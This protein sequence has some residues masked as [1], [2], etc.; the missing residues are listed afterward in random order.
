MPEV[1]IQMPGSLC[2]T[3][4]GEVCNGSCITTD[5]RQSKCRLCRR[6][7]YRFSKSS[8]QSIE[9]IEAVDWDEQPLGK[10]SDGALARMFDCDRST[11]RKARKA[12]NIPAF[13]GPGRPGPRA[14]RL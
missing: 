1:H 10:V 4:C 13:Q 6:R 11:V 7:L 3:W 2:D 9:A 8:L 5:P 12:R 14:V